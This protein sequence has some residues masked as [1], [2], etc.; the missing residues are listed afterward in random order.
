MLDET[1]VAEWAD[2]ADMSDEDLRYIAASANLVIR[3]DEILHDDHMS[4]EAFERINAIHRAMH[5]ITSDEEEDWNYPADM[6]HLAARLKLQSL[7]PSK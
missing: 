7:V 4:Q 1:E 3:A 5:T 6:S 2:S